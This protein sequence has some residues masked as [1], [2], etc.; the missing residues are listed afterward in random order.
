MSQLTEQEIV[1]RQSLEK[2]R[3]AGI[4]PYPAEAFKVTHLSSEIKA[5]FSEAKAEDFKVVSLSGRLM[6]K[7]I[8]GKASFAELMDSAGRIQIYMSR[9][10]ICPGEDKFL[11]NDLF[12]KL[13][14]IGDFVGVKGFIFLTQTGEVTLHVTEFNL[15]HSSF[16]NPILSPVQLCPCMIVF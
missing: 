11:Y 14:D 15:C 13:L 7:R 16:K 2:I 3:E 10:E 5:Q 4:D 6:M 12:K 8:M 1:R 9:D